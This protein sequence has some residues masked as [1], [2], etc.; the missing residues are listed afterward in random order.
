MTKENI[1]DIGKR[2]K[3]IRASLRLKQKDL[4]EALDMAGC[5]LSEL[6]SGKGNPCH[7]FFYKL[8]TRFGINLN[9]LFLGEGDMFRQTKMQEIKKNE[10]EKSNTMTIESLNL[11]IELSPLFKHQVLGFAGKFK[12]DNENIIKKDID[13][14][15]AEISKKKGPETG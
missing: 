7:A 4:A 9:Y 3:E 2:I 1:I 11:L 12:L 10:L 5:Y 13:N 15:M 14:N 8:C 6:E